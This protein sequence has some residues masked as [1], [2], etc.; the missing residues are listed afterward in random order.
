MARF[1]FAGIAGFRGERGL[2]LS[3]D[4]PA[5]ILRGESGLESPDCDTA[6]PLAS[7]NGKR[8]LESS[9]DW[10]WAALVCKIS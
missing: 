8:G 7:L 10:A 5:M 2:E 6:L 4:G 9:G 3:D 1:G